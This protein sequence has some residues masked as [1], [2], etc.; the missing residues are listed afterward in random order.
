MLWLR[1]LFGNTLDAFTRDAEMNLLR[2]T[3][4]CKC[5]Q[6]SLTKDIC[7]DCRFKELRE[8]VEMMRKM[9]DYADKLDDEGED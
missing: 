8:R 9:R 1:K 6:L 7:A 2:K 3:Y 4:L 5:G